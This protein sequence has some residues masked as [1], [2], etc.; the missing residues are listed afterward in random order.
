MVVL[1]LPSCVE[2]F[3]G[4]ISHS[5]VVGPSETLVF[6]AP[7]LRDKHKEE[8]DTRL[9]SLN[10]SLIAIKSSLDVKLGKS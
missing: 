8:I 4:R 2:D 10:S 3:E 1:S 9:R 6:V 5:V 7:E